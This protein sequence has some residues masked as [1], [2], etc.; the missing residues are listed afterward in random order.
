MAECQV[1]LLRG[2]NVGKAKRVAMADLRKLFSDLG[3]GDVRTVLNSGN[4]VFKSTAQSAAGCAAAI[5]RSLAERFEFDVPVVVKSAKELNAVLARHFDETQIYRIDHYLGK[6]TVQN[7]LTFR[8]A[9]AI[10]EPLLNRSH[11]DHVQITVAE[12][13]GMEGSRGG[14]YDTSGALRDVL[15]NHVLQL[16]CLLTL[17]LAGR[18]FALGTYFNLSLLVSAGLF[19]YQQYLIRNRERDACFR[20]FLHNNWV[21][22]AVCAG[23]VL[24]YGV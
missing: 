16:L 19:G 13:Q 2:I 18:A 7:I 1:A 10:F 23:I 6:E 14:Y 5:A 11:V 8:F 20:A 21:G 22:I 12:S 17:Y 15:Q 24:H 4:V 9:N 3:Y